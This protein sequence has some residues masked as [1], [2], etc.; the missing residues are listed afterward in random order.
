ML[1]RDQYIIGKDWEYKDPANLHKAPLLVNKL[2]SPEAPD[3][4][5]YSKKN[6]DVNSMSSTSLVLTADVKKARYETTKMTN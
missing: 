6:A 1:E 2:A 5:N 3:T 4:S